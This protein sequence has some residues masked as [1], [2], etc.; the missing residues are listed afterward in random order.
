VELRNICQ[1]N[2]LENRHRLFGP[3][4]AV[5][6][7]YDLSSGRV[8]CTEIVI[9]VIGTHCLGLEPKESAR[10]GTSKPAVTNE[11]P[12]TSEETRPFLN[13]NQTRY[14]AVNGNESD[15]S[16]VDS[17]SEAIQSCTFRLFLG[18]K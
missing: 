14:G 10:S 2:G 1:S 17:K 3:F 7:A 8:D 18:T 16:S 13:G 5:P 15:N 11:A 9:C 6:G 12:A 4:S